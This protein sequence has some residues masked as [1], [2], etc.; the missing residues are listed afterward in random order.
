M[1]K[2]FIICSFLMA[3]MILTPLF[4]MDRTKSVAA[5]PV[6]TQ[7]KSEDGTISVMLTENGK[8]QKMDEREYVIGAVAA[9]MDMGFQ[10]NAIMAQ[11]VVSYTYALYCKQNNGGTDALNGADIS[12]NSATNQ[13]YI[14]DKQRK[15][16]WGK[17]YDDYEKKLEAD[18]DSVFGKVIYYNDEPILAAYFDLS[19]GNTESAQ[20]VWGKNIPYLQSVQ[21]PGDKLSTSY[22]SVVSFSEDEFKKKA[23]TVDSVK[24]SG[25]ADKWLG[26]IDKT[27]TGYVKN[28]VVGS[29]TVAGKD[30]R[31]AFGLKSC[32][33]TVTYSSGKFTV[34]TIGNGHMVGMSQYGADYMARQGAD[35]KEI[36]NHYYTDVEVK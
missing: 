21:S 7:Q 28:I 30:F 13:G 19:S 15:E 17:N 11:A 4:T 14:N 35:W 2:N 23:E 36:I 18:V 29:S 20:T 10:D 33:F 31:L 34:K 5:A 16:K 8:V 9:E 25:A 26:K 32:N 12:D 22:T 1:R 24:I 6:T 3:A 27:D